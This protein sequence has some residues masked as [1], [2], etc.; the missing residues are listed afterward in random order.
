[1][2]RALLRNYVTALVAKSEPSDAHDFWSTIFCAELSFEDIA[3]VLSF[4]EVRKLRDKQPK[5]LAMLTI[6]SVEQVHL[7]A[8]FAE[9][10][11]GALQS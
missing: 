6:K 11:A 8:R 7:F 4:T 3:D 1:M 10:T 5:S 2:A 9:L